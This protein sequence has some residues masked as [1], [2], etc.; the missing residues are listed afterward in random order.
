[1]HF[2]LDDPDRM[3]STGVIDNLAKSI[4]PIVD[5]R[6]IDLVDRL[7]N[8]SG[9]D[10]AYK[11]AKEYFQE[12]GFRYI[13]V[14]LASK[15]EK[16]YSGVFS[17]MSENWLSY[18]VE[19]G[20]GACDIFFN[21]GIEHQERLICGSRTLFELPSKNKKLTD[22][23]LHDLRG[24]GWASSLVLPRHSQVSDRLVIFNLEADLEE[25]KI[26]EL[27]AKREGSVL[28]G[29]ALTQ[30]AIVQDY[31]GGD[32]GAHW[33]PIA[34]DRVTLSPR[35][36]EVLKWLAAGLR[37]D[38]ISERLNISL[39][40]VNFHVVSAKK[41]LGARTREQAVATAILDKLI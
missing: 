3:R 39:A 38:R 37:N 24:E 9:D 4:G 14:G 1:M 41:K 13:N 31:E 36:A 18:Y 6:L 7:D 33:H 21:Y 27:I 17:N 32:L 15:S 34:L 8:R 40:T 12:L 28:L 30:T 20:F 22:R 11:V 19:S 16:N 25:D 35:E 5:N 23:L 2:T 26:N 29:A 10:G